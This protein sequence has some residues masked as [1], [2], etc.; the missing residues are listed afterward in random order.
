MKFGTVPY[1]LRQA[2]VNVRN[3]P[4]VHGIGLLT[5]VISL[6]IFGAFLLLFVNANAWIESWGRSLSMSVYLKDGIGAEALAEI[7]AFIRSQPG[8]EIQR[9]ITKEEAL[10][11]F[12]EALGPRA[13]L[14]ESLGSNPLPASLE[15]VF[16][17]RPDGVEPEAVKRLAEALPGVDEVEYS[18]EW[19][20][21]FEGVMRVMGV[22]GFIIGGLLCL[23]ALFIMTNT[24]KLTIYGRKEEI[25][26]LK[27]VGATDWFVKTPFLVEGVILGAMSGILSLAALY[28]SYLLLSWKKIYIIGAAAL[29]F[30]FIPYEY[31]V[32]VFCISVLFGLLGSLIAVGRFFRF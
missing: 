18:R 26:I 7:E 20:R 23:G 16:K 10:A 5:M 25:E 1:F 13:R 12:R 19:I 27:L 11:E 31:S 9:L 2:A 4:A 28:A 3:N 14:L 24:I 15:V 30:V 32:G 6:L 22:A 17:E 21:R 29:D 8:A